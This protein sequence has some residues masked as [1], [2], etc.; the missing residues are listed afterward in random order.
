MSCGYYSGTLVLVY[1]RV[2]FQKI[3]GIVG[4][5]AA[6]CLLVILNITTPPQAGAIGVLTVFLLSYVVSVV[7]LAFFLFYV[8]KVVVKLFYSDRAQSIGRTFGF[9]RAYYYSSILALG[10]V[11]LV[12][13]RSVGRVGP[14]E[15][16]LVI[17]L[18]LLGCFYVSRQ[19]S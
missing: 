19:T 7:V 3:V 18:L 12:S 5:L 17:L 13:L 2:M 14:L 11:M 6:V 10:P 15:L 16:F 1:I 4:S 9:K 8:Y